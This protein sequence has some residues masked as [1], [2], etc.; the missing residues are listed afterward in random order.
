MNGPINIEEVLG[1]LDD[2]QGEDLGYSL[3]SWWDL[4][5][6][7]DG[8]WKVAPTRVLLSC[9]EPDFDNGSGANSKEQEDLRVDF[10]V[11]SHYLPDVELVGSGKL[12]ESNVKSLLRFVHEADQKPAGE[13]APIADLNPAKTSRHV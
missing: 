10:G 9:F 7:R 13:Q 12:A 4:W 3:E 8:D 2:Y 1:V 6:F 11:D 5:V